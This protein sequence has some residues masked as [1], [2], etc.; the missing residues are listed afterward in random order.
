[1]ENIAFIDILEKNLIL[2]D[3]NLYL[4]VDVKTQTD[5]WKQW[6][7]P[8][9]QNRNEWQFYYDTTPFAHLKKV[10][11]VVISLKNGNI[12]N[13]ILQT[14][15]SDRWGFIAS[16]PFN[17]SNVSDH[18]RRLLTVFF[19]NG[20]EHL[21][22]W[23]SPKI[24]RTC[25]TSNELDEEDKHLLMH[26]YYSIYCPNNDDQFL[27]LFS[28][29]KVTATQ[30]LLPNNGWLHIEQEFLDEINALYHESTLAEMAVELFKSA[31]MIC[32]DLQHSQVIKGLDDGL[33]QAFK[34]HRTTD[35]VRK[36]FAFSRFYF[37]SHFWQL[38]EFSLSVKL[39]SLGDALYQLSRRTDWQ[40]NIAKNHHN[41]LWLQELEGDH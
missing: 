17:L 24:L 21:F 11:P 39:S 8:L 9:L 5:F 33:T 6:D 35:N 30:S 32:M 16:S 37:G 27:P 3:A 19:P 18:F 12:G 7:K 25:L 26:P 4:F 23:Y 10:S 14:L 2:P 29:T 22:R 36:L 1:M 40:T 15:A 31:P 28:N 41:K 13:D 20:H 34:Y 38:P